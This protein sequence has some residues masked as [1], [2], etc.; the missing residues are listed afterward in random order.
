MCKREGEGANF[1]SRGTYKNPGLCSAPNPY[2][3]RRQVGMT[4]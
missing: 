4:L 2:P 3:Y 1:H